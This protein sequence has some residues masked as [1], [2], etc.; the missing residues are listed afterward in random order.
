M[1]ADY[2]LVSSGE[3]ALTEIRRRFNP[4]TRSDSERVAVTPEAGEMVTLAAGENAK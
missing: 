1:S 4:P 3:W 2:L